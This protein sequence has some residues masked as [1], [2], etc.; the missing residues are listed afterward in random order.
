MHGIKDLFILLVWCFVTLWFK[1]LIVFRESCCFCVM[2]FI[3]LLCTWSLNVILWILCL[4]LALLS[5]IIKLNS[6]NDRWSF[7]H[8]YNQFNTKQAFSALIAS[9]CFLLSLLLETSRLLL[10]LDVLSFTEQ[11][12]A[13][14]REWLVLDLHWNASD[15][16]TIDEGFRYTPMKG[17]CGHVV[18]E[19]VSTETEGRCTLS[20]ERLH[21]WH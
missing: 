6:S 9:V 20:T 7:Q 13:G 10:S 8:L 16:L 1:C 12:R 14:Q 5:A 4:W 11:F 19:Y 21:L 15:Q 18:C 17:H 2:T 3:H